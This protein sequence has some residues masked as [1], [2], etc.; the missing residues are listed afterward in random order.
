MIALRHDFAFVNG[1]R[2]HYVELGQGP[3]VLLCHGWPESWYSW[4]H[5]IEVLA[6]GGFR[7]VAPDQRGYGLT[8]AP[9]AIDDYNILNLVGDLVGLTHALGEE[10][11]ILIGHDWGS[12][13]A[14]NAALL[15]PDI[16][17]A[18]GLL[19]VPYVPRRKLRPA[20]RFE[21]AAQDKHFYQHYFQRPGVIEKELE[22]DIRHS[23]L[24]ILYTLAG[25]AGTT[26]P[27]SNF[28]VFDKK[29]RFV[30]NLVRPSALPAWLLERDLDFFVE[31]FT[32]SGFR[33]PINWY[34]N[35]DRNWELTAFLDGAKIR[36][37]TLFLSGTRDAVL[38]MTHED[39]DRLETT[40]PN[41]WKKY[42]IAD[43]GHWTQQ[44]RPS[45]VSAVL[46]EFIKHATSV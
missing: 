26:H 46:L 7:V 23:L 33:G 21:L 38:T 16:F 11:A 17:R 15:R 32:R 1:I 10:D 36:Q 18:I 43:A 39:V 19:S 3:L 42:L 13:V 40:V 44:E 4:R 34:R 25:E 2:M 5:Q 9:A 8:D 22:E 29:K 20:V 30:D 14:A 37:P 45:E 28:V 41:L 27:Q 24:G 6:A 12:I 35:F 31:Q